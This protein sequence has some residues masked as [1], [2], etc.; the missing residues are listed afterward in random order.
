MA[1]FEVVSACVG[2]MAATEGG[3]VESKVNDLIVFADQ[4]EQAA[5]KRLVGHGLIT[6]PDPGLFTLHRQ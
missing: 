5:L 1:P 4:I 2:L 6:E 3:P